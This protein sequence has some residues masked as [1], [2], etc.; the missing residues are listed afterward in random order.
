MKSDNCTPSMASLAPAA[1][2]GETEDPGRLAPPARR[3]VATPRTYQVGA[4]P[5]QQGRQFG[6]PA[7]CAGTARQEYIAPSRPAIHAPTGT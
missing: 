4:A 6:F 5:P 2:A 1:V 7:G 3:R